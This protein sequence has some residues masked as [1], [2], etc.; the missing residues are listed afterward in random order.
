[1]KLAELLVALLLGLL[2]IA[3]V[4]RNAASVRTQLAALAQRAAQVEARRVVGLVLDAEAGGFVAGGAE[5]ELPVRAH[6]WWGV[7]CDTLPV[8]GRAT[9]HLQGLRRPEPDKD[10]LLV[11]TAAGRVQLRRLDHARAVAACGGGAVELGWTAHP[12]DP[13][14]R[15]VRGFEYGAYRLDAAFRYR[16]GAGGAQPLTAELFDPDSVA[17]VGDSTGV[18]LRIGAGAARRWSREPR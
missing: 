16:R 2:L 14:A 3:L 4:W 17:L 15:L 1:M 10:S 11:V 6:R 9:V 8:A 18:L 5:G 13:P 7:V 12:D